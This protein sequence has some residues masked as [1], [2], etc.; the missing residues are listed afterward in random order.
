MIKKKESLQTG[1]DCLANP[2]FCLSNNNESRTQ[3]EDEC[4]KV[5]CDFIGTFI[6][7]DFQIIRK[8]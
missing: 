1:K 4:L 5:P 2:Y 8:E 3:A 7:G 6:Q